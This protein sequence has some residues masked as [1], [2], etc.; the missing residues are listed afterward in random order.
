MRAHR[1][2]WCILHNDLSSNATACLMKAHGVR[3]WHAGG[4]GPCHRRAAAWGAGGGAP[5]VR[6]VPWTR[7]AAA[8]SWGGRPGG[9]LLACLLQ[10][11]GW[12]ATAV[13]VASAWEVLPACY[14][15]G[16]HK[17]ATAAS[18]QP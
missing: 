14:M 9:V 1:R 18:A 16:I 17:R 15:S 4:R 5:H 13:W 11:K 2:S 7:W 10:G 3:C 12:R 8:G 6:A